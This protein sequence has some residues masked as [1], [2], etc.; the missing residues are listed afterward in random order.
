[1]V[2]KKIPL[3]WVDVNVVA[4]INHILSGFDRFC[5]KFDSLGK[6][7][8]LVGHVGAADDRIVNKT[9]DQP[10]VTHVTLRKVALFG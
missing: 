10:H 1:M 9:K 4:S 5:R 3:P 2:G 6:S 7:V 8:W